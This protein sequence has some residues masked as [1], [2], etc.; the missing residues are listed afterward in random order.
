MAR[1]D[2]IITKVRT[3]SKN[4]SKSEAITLL[5]HLGFSFVRY[6]RHSE[7]YSSEERII[8]LNRHKKTIHSKAIKEIRRILEDLLEE[9]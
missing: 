1:I 6:T 8:S 7:F 4:L 2:K 5:E 3:G 9:E